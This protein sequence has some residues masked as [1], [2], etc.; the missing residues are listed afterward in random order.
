MESKNSLFWIGLGVGSVIG[1][2]AYR[3]SRTSKCRRWKH[4]ACHALHEAGG[5]AGNFLEA[6]KEK[7]VTLGN[8]VAD[9]VA[10]KSQEAVEKVDE[11]KDKMRSF[12]SEARK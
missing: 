1:A 4:K 11:M 10:D 12:A 3:F 9:A 7:A 5:H 6:A 2:V 8:K